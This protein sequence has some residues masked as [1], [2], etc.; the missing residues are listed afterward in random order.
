MTRDDLKERNTILTGAF[1]AVDK[2]LTAQIVNDEHKRVIRAE[3][4]EILYNLL[5]GDYE[6]VTR[7]PNIAHL[8]QVIGHEKSGSGI[9]QRYMHTFPLSTVCHII[10]VPN[11][12]CIKS[13]DKFRMRKESSNLLIRSSLMLRISPRF[14]SLR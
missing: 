14:L 11:W 13:R 6:E 7:I 10:D 5:K 9:T 12:L 8:Q 4:D 3:L 2:V 1:L